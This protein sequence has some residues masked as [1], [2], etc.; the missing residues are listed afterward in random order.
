VSQ[1]L[2]LLRE[3][4]EAQSKKIGDGGE[5]EGQGNAF[6]DIL[7][8]WSYAA[9]VTRFGSSVIRIVAKRF[10]AEKQPFSALGGCVFAGVARADMLTQ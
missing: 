6:M 9:Q 8:V 2:K 4:L 3:W 1:S 5:G 10:G 7:Q